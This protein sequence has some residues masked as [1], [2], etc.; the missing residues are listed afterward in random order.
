MKFYVY[1]FNVAM[2]VRGKTILMSTFCFLL[3]SLFFPRHISKHVSNDLWVLNGVAHWLEHHLVTK[4]LRFDSRLG[5][6]PRLCVHPWAEHRCLWPHS[7]DGTMV[8]M[9]MI[10]GPGSDPRFG[11]I[12][13]N[14]SML[15]SHLCPSLS[16]FLSPLLSLS[17][18]VN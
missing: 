15:L 18:K 3:L 5:H 12:K 10:L 16:L 7:P 2:V 4:G 8:Q 14:Q 13:G 11:C 1:L 6:I 9:G 17:K